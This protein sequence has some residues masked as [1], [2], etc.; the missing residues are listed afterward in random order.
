MAYF[1]SAG[2][3]LLTSEYM[4]LNGASALAIPTK[5]GQELHSDET[6]G[7]G[8][9]YWEALHQG[10]EWLYAEIDYIKWE[11]IRTNLPQNARFILSTLQNLQALS[12]SKLQSDDNYYFR[13]NLQ[14]PA[15]YGLG[16]SSTLIANLAKWADADA[17]LLN[18][19]SLGGSGYD[20][21]VAIENTAIIYRLSEKKRTITPISFSPSYRDELI[22][23]HLNQKQDS[24]EGINMF[25]NKN[26]PQD[27]IEAFSHFT[28]AVLKADNLGEFSELMN[29][30]E[31]ILS[32]FLGIPRVQ[33]QYFHDCPSFVKSL[34]AWGGD[35]IL[36]SKFKGYKNY[37]TKRGFPIIFDYNEL[38]R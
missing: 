17:F 29:R 28:N 5:I 13:T 7:N 33:K 14:F 8:R 3:L 22:F 20:I 36:S 23:I 21:A 10:K 35:F 16:S 30:H 26:P 38:I 19:K 12:S 27:L 9:I 32:D 1:F 25:K 24:R 15:N 18:E 34:G 11:I 2:K 31:I 6:P 4:V 37:F